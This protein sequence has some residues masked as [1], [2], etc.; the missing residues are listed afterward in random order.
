VQ[1]ATEHGA[2]RA[3]PPAETVDPAGPRR[4]DADRTRQALLDAA[5]RRFARNGYAATTV[6]DIAQDAG[7]NVALISRYFESKAGLFEAC[8]ESAGRAMSR[9]AGTVTTPGE[10]AAAIGRQTAAA[11]DSGPPDELLILL[12]SSGD[13]HAERIRIGVLRS[14]SER[15]SDLAAPGTGRRADEDALLRAQLVLAAGMGIGLLRAAGGPEPLMSA[16]EADLAAPLRDLVEGL[17]L[18]G[19]LSRTD[20]PAGPAPSPA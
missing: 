2:A 15:L 10:V 11:P 4:R 20:G 3:V 8:L 7:V 18:G 19:G 14:Y 1:S 13:E 16:T 12:R 9:S 5:H 17:L 6:R